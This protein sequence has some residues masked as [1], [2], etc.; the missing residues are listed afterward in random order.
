MAL[1][2]SICNFSV[3][4]EIQQKKIPQENTQKQCP[5]KKIKCIVKIHQNWICCS[6]IL[7]RHWC[8]ILFFSL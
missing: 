7:P 3:S 8:L 5:S 2:E 1:S 4:T 6:L